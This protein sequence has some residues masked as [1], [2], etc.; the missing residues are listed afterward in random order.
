MPYAD[1]VAVVDDDSS[2]LLGISSLVS[3]FGFDV[4]SFQSGAELLARGIAGIACIITDIQMPD[5]NGIDLKRRLD[6]AE[7]AVPVIMITARTEVDLLCRVQAAQPFCILHKPFEA[8]E[9]AAC[10]HRALEDKQAVER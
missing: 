3:S 10:L 5:M 8:D 2:A 1:L 4:E 9:L 7:S 6:A